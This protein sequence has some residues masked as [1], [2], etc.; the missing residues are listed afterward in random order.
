MVP[1]LRYYMRAGS[2]FSPVP[3]GVLEGMFGRRPQPH[4]FPR[5]VL[6][7]PWVEKDF[8]RVICGITLQNGGPVMARD[9]YV[10]VTVLSKPG[11]NCRISSEMLERSHWTASTAFGVRT[12]LTS[13]DGY[14]LAPDSFAQ[15]IVLNLEFS[16]PFDAGL[17]VQILVGCE[18]G[19]PYRGEWVN[20]CA[21]LEATF[22]A[23]LNDQLS[24]QTAAESLLAIPS[25]S[26]HGTESEESG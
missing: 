12:S 21:D 24:G 2:A 3:H 10:V 25:D 1:D 22:Q 15:P 14:K 17:E 19:L 18:G 7:P 5:Y 13:N 16:R 6:T 4:V 23:V 8:V 20:S 11:P 9:I 26:E